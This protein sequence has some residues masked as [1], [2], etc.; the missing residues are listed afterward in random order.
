MAA[1]SVDRES[2]PRGCSCC[3]SPAHHYCSP[4]RTRGR[5][6]HGLPA[7]INGG[8]YYSARE[9]GGEEEEHRQVEVDFGE[10]TGVF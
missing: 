7:R 6:N 2:R 1:I 4:S 8:G 5:G 10:A 3:C 9:G